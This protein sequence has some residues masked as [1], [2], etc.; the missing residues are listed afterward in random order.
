MSRRPDFFIVGFPKC[1]TTSLYEYLK[2][3]P[4]IFM[5]PA[6][7]PRYFSDP[8][9]G[10][11][12]RHDLIYPDDEQ[13]YLSLYSDARDQRRLGEATTTYVYSADAA[14]RIREFRPDARVIAMVRDPIAMIQSFHSQ[15]VDD[16]HE[17]VKEFIEAIGPGPVGRRQFYVDSAGYAR[18]LPRW[19]NAFG[20][21]R[22]LVIVMED[23]AQDPAGTFS[24]VLEFLDVDSG[25][26]PDF[27][28]FNRRHSTRFPLLRRALRSPVPTWLLRRALP[29]VVGEARVRRVVRRLRHSAIG[30]TEAQRTPLS[31]N[32][33]AELQ[34]EL[35]PDVAALSEMLQRDLVSRW[36]QA[37]SQ[38][39]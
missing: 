6:K 27:V 2:G 1:G 30:R 35:A 31:S 13:R 4:D 18:H 32:V 34:R 23:M 5:S 39:G 10:L 21:E 12:H 36:W 3:H 15:L 37:I 24:R 17:S 7:E 9:D 25:Y 29:A 19:F 33:R 8:T 16:G 20:R 38:L 14:Q 28:A 11:G 22:V 26:R